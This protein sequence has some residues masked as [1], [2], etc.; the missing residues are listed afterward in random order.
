[1]D[2]LN[3]FA[4]AGPS[5]M[6]TAPQDLEGQAMKINTVGAL[7]CNDFGDLCRESTRTA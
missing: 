1:M 6:R 2:R 4:I 5:M 3:R 7:F